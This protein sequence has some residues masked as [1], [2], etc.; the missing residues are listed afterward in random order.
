MDRFSKLLE[1]PY[2][3]F[4]PLSWSQIRDLRDAGM[5]VGAHT[6]TH[7]NL[8]RSDAERA[9]WEMSHSK[10]VLEQE[11]GQE[12]DSMAYPFGK[13]GR[14]VTDETVGI[15]R[16][17]GYR[18]AGVILHRGVRPSDPPLSIPRV[19]IVEENVKE[20]QA[21]VWGTLDMVGF[22][23]AWAPRWMGRMVTPQDFT[24][25]A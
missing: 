18:T 1:S 23:Q 6:A 14:H 19:N 8:A 22:G 13:P 2:E 12:V 20:L 24:F 4:E 10:E 11:L 15:A 17:L 16:E 7:G 21:R 25:E 9:R 3:D 5:E